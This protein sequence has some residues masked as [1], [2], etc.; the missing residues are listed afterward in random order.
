MRESRG[1][2]ARS[3]FILLWLRAVTYML[4]VRERVPAWIPR[5]SWD[6]VR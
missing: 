1:E 3:E 4:G 5:L 6:H 2:S